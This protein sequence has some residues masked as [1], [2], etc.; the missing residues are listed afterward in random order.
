MCR[1]TAAPSSHRSAAPLA[2]AAT[3]TDARARVD[4]DDDSNARLDAARHARARP[5]G[6]ARRARSETA[7]I[8]EN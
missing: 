5:R 3:T 2:R 7:R 4:D 1:V 8:R 6:D